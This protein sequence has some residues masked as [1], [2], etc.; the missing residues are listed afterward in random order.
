MIPILPPALED[1][2]AAHTSAPSALLDE[3]ER[4][5]RAHCEHSQMLVG[6][7]EGAFLKML[8][9]LSGARRILEIGLFTGYSALTMAEALPDDGTIISCDINAANAAIAQSF[10]DRSPHGRKITIRLGP[11]LETLKSFPAEQVFDLVFLDADKENYLNYY[12]AVL[13]HIKAG[14][15]IVA[16]NVLW[17]GKV[18][19]PSEQTDHAIVAFNARV[20]RDSR[21]EA[22]MLGV[23]DGMFVIRKR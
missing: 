1:Y 14:G 20:V 21:V 22:V 10:F 2:C 6:R 23:R 19:A 5:T 11:A 9:K 16:D 17:S 12:E 7:L 4:H 13:P 15:L 18:L 8:I 3:L